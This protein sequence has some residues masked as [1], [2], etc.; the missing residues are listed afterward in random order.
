ME[1]ANRVVGP[2][3]QEATWHGMRRKKVE[4]QRALK[5]RTLGRRVTSC[6]CG[7]AL[8]IKPSSACLYKIQWFDGDVCVA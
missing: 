2:N 8:T 6:V 1:E 4:Q 7:G 5:H 3:H